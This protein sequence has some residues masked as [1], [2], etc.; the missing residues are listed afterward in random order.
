MG[1]TYQSISTLDKRNPDAAWDALRFLLR[2][3]H[4]RAAE[5]LVFTD[6]AALF[7]IIDLEVK[8]AAN[9]LHGAAP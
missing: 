3:A 2:N 9:R 8:S 6:I 1:Q 5:T 7:F 4:V